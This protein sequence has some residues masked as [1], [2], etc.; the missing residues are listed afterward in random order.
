[1]LD[2]R[3][4][5]LLSSTLESREIKRD[6][7]EHFLTSCRESQ[8]TAHEISL[9]WNVVRADKKNSSHLDE[10]LSDVQEVF[11]RHAECGGRIRRLELMGTSLGPRS[12][13]VVDVAQVSFD[14]AAW[15]WVKR[16]Y[17]SQLADAAEVV[18]LGGQVKLRSAD[19]NDDEDEDESEDDETDGDNEPEER[20]S[21]ESDDEY[22]DKGCASSDGLQ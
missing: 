11:C 7:A 17:V 20:C 4:L 8:R 18:N 15:W 5:Q 6:I 14:R 3:R 12:N 19:D 22:E 2:L 10:E 16:A 13:K 21:E 1:M 9:A